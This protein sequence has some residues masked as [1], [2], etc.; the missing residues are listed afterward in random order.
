MTRMNFAWLSW[1]V[2]WEARYWRVFCVSY[3]RLTDSRDTL[4]SD[5]LHFRYFDGG[6]RGKVEVPLSAIR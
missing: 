4:I 1:V 6:P 2:G 3:H 5:P